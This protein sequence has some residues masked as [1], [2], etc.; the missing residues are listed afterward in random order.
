M[1]MYKDLSA[2]YNSAVN[3]NDCESRGRVAAIPVT[4]IVADFSRGPSAT[5]I[6]NG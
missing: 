3:T 6:S 4:S 5:T 1:Y 2:R